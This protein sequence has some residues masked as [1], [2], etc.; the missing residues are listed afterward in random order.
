MMV[1]ACTRSVAVAVMQSPD[2]AAAVVRVAATCGGASAAFG[3]WS[4]GGAARGVT[5]EA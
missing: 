5:W 2:P 3:R 1:V 4:R